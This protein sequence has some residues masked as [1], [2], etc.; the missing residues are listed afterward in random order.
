M[1]RGGI[2]V[3]VVDADAGTGD[4]AEF[5]GGGEDGGSDFC[6]GADYESVL[7]SQ[8]QCHGIVVRYYSMCLLGWGG[9]KGGGCC[10]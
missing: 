10:T 4:D 6:G 8:G 3:N 9:E 2:D 5:G 7:E 1:G